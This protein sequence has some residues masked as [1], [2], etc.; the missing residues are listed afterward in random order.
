MIKKGQLTC[1]H[2]DFDDFVIR[3][4]NRRECICEGEAA[5]RGQRS[6]D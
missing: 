1:L 5:R 6:R 3:A 2:R 4:G